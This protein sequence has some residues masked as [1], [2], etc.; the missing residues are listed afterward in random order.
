M[1]GIFHE[2]YNLVTLNSE[3]KDDQ[4]SDANRVMYP[5]FFRRLVN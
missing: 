5:L 1:A 3:V 2:G 4:D